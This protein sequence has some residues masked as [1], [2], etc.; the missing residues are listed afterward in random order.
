MV[1]GDLEFEEIKE[2]QDDC[3]AKMVSKKHYVHIIK[4]YGDFVDIFDPN[5]G[6]K[7][8]QKRE[9]FCEFRKKRNNIN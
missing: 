9:D 4:V 6:Y 8:K 1:W 2:P 5:G 3:V 7:S